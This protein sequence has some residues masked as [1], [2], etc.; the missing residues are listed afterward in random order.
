MSFTTPVV[1]GLD[2]NANYG[3][4]VNAVGIF[5]MCLSLATVVLRFFSRAYTKI[6]IGTDDWLLLGAAVWFLI[7]FS[8]LVSDFPSLGLLLG[9][10]RYRYCGSGA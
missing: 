5:F 8:M 4:Q 9:L 3:P 2:L 10:Y 6:E 1:P 7:P